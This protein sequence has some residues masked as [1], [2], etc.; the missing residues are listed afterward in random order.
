AYNVGQLVVDADGDGMP[1]PG[2]T[3]RY[4]VIVVNSGTANATGVRLDNALDP[5]ASL[6]VGSVNASLGSVTVGNNSGDTSVVVDFGTVEAGT[7]TTVTFDVTINDPLPASVTQ[8]SNQ[9]MISS[10]ELPTILTTDPSDPEGGNP[11]GIVIAQAPLLT[12]STVDT[13]F[14]DADGDGIPSPGDTLLYKVTI[15]NNGNLSANGVVFQTTPTI[16]TALVTGSVQSSSGTIVSGNT[17]GDTIAGVDFG[18]LAPADIVLITYKVTVDDPLPAG[19]TVIS[20]QGTV[21]SDEIPVVLTDDPASEGVG[22]PTTTIVVAAPALK[23]TKA[24]SLLMDVDTNGR[25]SPGD[26]ILYSIDITNEGNVVASDVTYNDTP[27]PNTT[28]VVGS[29]KSNASTIISGN[30]PGDSSVSIDLGAIAPGRTVTITYE[31]T[32]HDPLPEGVTHVGSQG[33]V[34]SMELPVVLT[35]DPHLLG[36]VDSTVSPVMATPV[37]TASKTALLLADAD[38]N[39][40]PSAG[41]TLLY[42]IEIL[43]SGN[44][45]ATVT[46][47]NDTIDTNTTLVAGTVQTSQGQVASG[48]SPGDTR[49]SVDIGTITGHGGNATVS[50]KVTVNDPLPSGVALVSNQGEITTSE[51]PP[52][53]TDDPTLPGTADSTGTAVTN[54]PLLFASMGDTLSADEDGDGIPSPGDTLLYTVIIHNPGNVAMTGVIFGDTPDS[55]TALQ[56]GSVSASQGTVSSGNSAGS[57]YVLVDIGTIAG[58]QSVTITFKAGISE[59]LSPSVAEICNQGTVSSNELPDILTSDP[60]ATETDEPTVTVLA[61]VNMLTATKTWVL[62]TD[63]DGNDEPSPGDTLGYEVTISNSG[64]T[65][66][67]GIIFSDTPDRNTALMA[68]SVQTS[69]GG[70]ITGN[71]AD[72]TSVSVDVGSIPGGNSVA[73]SFEVTVDDS[74]QAGVT[75]VSNQGTVSSTELPVITTDDPD[76]AGSA[77]PTVTMIIPTKALAAS[78]SWVLLIDADGNTEPSPGD[79]LGYD[80]TISN[81]GSVGLSGVVFNDFLDPNTTL[82]AG[83]VWTS[84]GTVAGGNVADGAHVRV[85]IGTLVANGTV[86]ISY[87]ARIHETLPQDVAQISNQG[88]VESYE[89]RDVVTD[90]PRTPAVNDPTIVKVSP[91]SPAEDLWPWIVVAPMLFLSQGLILLLVYPLRRWRLIVVMRRH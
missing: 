34:S 76:I 16:G 39:G 66:V 63:A 85:E 51:L 59:A 24:D 48:N 81:G 64:N 69:A 10:N 20:H 72:D 55:N 1:S 22:D 25:T 71:T 42:R 68:G 2:D 13:L 83:S 14:S 56:V 73:I 37:L 6:I 70:V 74:L 90:D 75:Q 60:A 50:F 35:D 5:N 7:F 62:L 26:T 54:D 3:I 28:L 53:L 47:L 29:V 80:V 18:T 45:N 41:D 9:G 27:D 17:H 33:M 30:T 49:I 88:I 65:V 15:T 43:N 11:T 82:V 58:G 89:L 19:R 8:I 86:A 91:P 21:T 31:V 79:T 23:A 38:S 67:T 46:F 32:I 52:I 78:K 87:Q 61:P 36:G 4:E 12:A 77:D 44:Q 57:T 40:V 84:L